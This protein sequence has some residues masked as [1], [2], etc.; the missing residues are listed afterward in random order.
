MRWQG[1]RQ[2]ENV[3]DQR[4]MGPVGGGGMLG[5]RGV[6]VGGFGIGG[7][8]IIL[9]LGL[10][11]GFDPSFLLN[12][13]YVDEAPAPRSSPNNPGTTNPARMPTA[14]SGAE[15]D[16]ADF[17]SVVLAETEDVWGNIF[18]QSGRRYEEPVLVLFSNA[19]QSGCGSARSSMGPFYCP[20]DRKLYIDL[21]FYRDLRNRMGAPGDFAQAYVIAHEVGHHVQNLLG[22]SRDV[23]AAQRQAS[24]S[25]ANALSVRLELQADCF[26][27]IWA[28]SMAQQEAVLEE[29]DIE[30]ALNAAS[31]VGDDRLQAQ[32]TGMVTPDS[33]T[34]GSSE[35]RVEWFR[36]GLDSGSPN[37]CDTFGNG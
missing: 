31:A 32:S 33:F 9:L 14:R 20:A 24:Q 36:R 17:V 18:S 19:V 11:F 29:G 2:S 3:E 34:H 26:A 21:S 8:L 10:I 23:Q 16:L 12:G 5:G 35:Q 1:R 22:V 30:E 13:G 25:E 37:S 28:H 15:G 27:G 6:R 7:T 4:G